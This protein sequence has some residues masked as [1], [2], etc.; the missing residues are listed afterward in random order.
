[1]SVL[2]SFDIC[3]VCRTAWITSMNMSALHAPACPR[4]VKIAAQ[5][6]LWFHCWYPQFFNNWYGWFIIFVQFTCGF[7]FNIV[8]ENGSIFISVDALFGC[9]RKSGAGTSGKASNHGE[10][11]FISQDKVDNFLSTY[12]KT[13][14]S[15]SMVIILC[16]LCNNKYVNFLKFL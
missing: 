14:T 8:Q 1:M 6:L 10:E 11:L 7:H 13:S 12:N 2:A 5:L 3:P 15:K 4:F 9:V 16:M